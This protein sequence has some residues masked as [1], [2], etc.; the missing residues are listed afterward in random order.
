LLAVALFLTAE[1][2]PT[3]ADSI[4]KFDEY[5]NLRPCD[6]AARLDNFAIQMQ[7]EKESFGYV[8]V[9]APEPDSKRIRQTITDYLTK[10]RGLPRG[11]IKTHHAGY[12]DPLSEPLVQLYVLPKGVEPPTSFARDVNVARFKGML[13]EYQESDPI[14]LVRPEPEEDHGDGPAVGSV[15]FAAFNDVFKAQKHSIAHVVVYNGVGDVPGTWQRVAESTVEDLKRFGFASSR[16]KI[17]YG[18]QSKETKVQLWI[19]PPGESPPVKDPATE[20]APA[21][22][23]KIGSFDN[24]IL[25]HARNERAVFDRLLLVLRENPDLR[26]YLVVRMKVP[27]EPVN[28]PKLVD[29]WKNEL[30]AKHQMRN[31]RI[32]VLFANAEEHLLPTVELW[33]VPP[34]QSII[35]QDIQSSP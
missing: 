12:N 17:A 1:R 15:V 14:V 20:P 24:G 19:L 7:H 23:I 18:G 16:F 13:A 10:T 25:D 3:F 33:V 22:A 30:T 29:K 35:I 21:Q 6:H 9:Y 8:V 28:L 31:D 32:V 2:H 11:R 5:G 26:A 27:E 34:G 4:R